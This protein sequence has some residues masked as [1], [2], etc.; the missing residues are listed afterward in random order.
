MNSLFFSL[1]EPSKL[2]PKKFLI[3]NSSK[4]KAFNKKVWK[5]EMKTNIN[6]EDNERRR[7]RPKVP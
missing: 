1:F 5:L 3:K 6:F 2:H 7:R 4:Q